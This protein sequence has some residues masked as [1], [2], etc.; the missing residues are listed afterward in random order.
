M[1]DKV[2]SSIGLSYRPASP[3]SP[4]TIVHP[5]K[6]VIPKVSIL[7]LS[8]FFFYYYNL[9]EM[10]RLLFQTSRLLICPHIPS[11]MKLFT[12]S[13]LLPLLLQPTLF[14]Q[15]INCIKELHFIVY[16]FSRI[17]NSLNPKV[18]LLLVALF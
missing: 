10:L 1:G 13:P 4:C 5:F 11:R 8:K 18:L 17:N 7:K 16:I 15:K 12:V 9:L 2:D 14:I 6:I 3:F